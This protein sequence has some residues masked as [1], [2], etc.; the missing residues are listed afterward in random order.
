MEKIGVF[1]GSFNPVHR[2][3]VNM[4]LAAIKTFS[5]D[6]LIVMPTFI[7]PHKK[8]IALA[9]TEDRLQALKIAF[10][11]YKNIEISDYEIKKE[12]VSFTYLTLGHLKKEYGGELYFLMGT[13]MLADFPTWRNPKEIL[14]LAKLVVTARD[15]ENLAKALTDHYE[16]FHERPLISTYKGKNYSST[17]VRNYL[18]L[19]LDVSDYIDPRV[20]KFL[21]ER[22]TYSGGKYAYIA[23]Y[24][25]KALKKKRIVHTAGVMTLAEEYAKRLG[26]DREKA[27]L[28]AMLHDVAKYNTFE[29]F[30]LETPKDLPKNVVH[31]F[32]GAYVAE[33]ILKIEDE[34]VLNAV[35]YHTTGR[36]NMTTLEKIIFTADFLEEG[37]TFD[38]VE[39]L[40]A[41]VDKDFDEGFATCVRELFGFLKEKNA[42]DDIYYLSAEC[43]E[44][45]CK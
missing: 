41:A 20:E 37:R 15:G 31:Q 12:G 9:P 28:A 7:S 44:Y 22:G 43:F 16:I 1:G 13:D 30:G 8:N 24:L 2:E 21:K 45:Y 26:E 3:H 14:S 10:S 38:G 29:D 33:H 6:R 42:E 39:R 5:L 18:A 27:R 25:N 35:R 17:K 36:A 32:L 4:A 19:G 34:D 23:E 11:D 40:R